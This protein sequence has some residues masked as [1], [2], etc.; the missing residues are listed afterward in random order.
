MAPRG[1]KRENVELLKNE[2][3]ERARWKELH[4]GAGGLW[5]ICAIPQNFLQGQKES[6][7][8]PCDMEPSIKCA[9]CSEDGVVRSGDF[10]YHFKGSLG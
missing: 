9:G 6:P 2:W 4:A 5:A 1:I 8:S 10:N 7:P 3:N